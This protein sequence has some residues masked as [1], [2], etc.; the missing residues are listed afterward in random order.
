M[1]DCILVSLCISIQTRLRERGK[2]STGI[3]EIM[4]VGSRVGWTFRLLHARVTG[5]TMTELLD[6]IQAGVHANDYRVIAHHNLHSLYLFQRR[7]SFREFYQG[8]VS[9]SPIDGMPLVWIANLYGHRVSRDRR[10][11]YV[12][13]L[14][15]MLEIAA[16][17]RWRVFY[18]GSRPE[19]CEQGTLKLMSLYPGIELRSTHGYFDISADSAENRSIVKEIAEFRPNVLMVGMGMPRQ[20]EWISQNIDKLPAGVILPCGAAMDYLAGAIPTPPRWAGRVGLEWF[21]RLL[22]EPRR[23]ASRY[24]VEPWFLLPVLIRDLCSRR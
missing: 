12:D 17:K 11:T 21:F 23:L 14:P 24:L 13:F 15:P 16:A 3:S 20:E 10:I 4:S 5:L 6:E 8:V 9:C 18:L 1:C 19:I 22:A 2:V 7:Q